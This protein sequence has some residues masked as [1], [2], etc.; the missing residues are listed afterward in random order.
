MSPSGC[1]PKQRANTLAAVVDCSD[2]AIISKD[3][4]GTINAWNRGAE[5]IFGYSAS[6]AVGRPMLMLFPPD[7]A[8]EES[9]ILARIRRG[10]SVEHFETVRVR[11]DGKQIDVSVTISPVKDMN[12]TIVGASK[13]ARDITERKQAEARLSGQ[14]EDFPASRGT[15]SLAGGAGNPNPH[16][17]V[18]TRQ[19]GRGSSR[20]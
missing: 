1:R 9:D 12:G 13:I 16:A 20:S 4:N 11:K 10:E 15:A 3:L 8:D 6:E 7:R 14:A 18:R 2:D 17:A 19:H 5:K